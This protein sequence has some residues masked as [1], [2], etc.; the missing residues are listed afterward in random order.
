MDRWKKSLLQDVLIPLFIH[1]IIFGQNYDRAQSLGW[2]ATPHIDGL[3]MLHQFLRFPKTLEGSFIKENNFVT[4]FC[5]SLLVLQV[6]SQSVLGVFLGEKW[7]L[8]C[9]SR[10]QAVVLCSNFVACE[11]I[12]MQSNEGCTCFWR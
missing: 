2:K 11:D 5:C 6:E 9:P 8:C 12:L 1:G 10:H 4:V 7:F 3:G